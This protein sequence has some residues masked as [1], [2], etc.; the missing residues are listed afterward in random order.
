M[1]LKDEIRKTKIECFMIIEKHFPIKRQIEL[2]KAAAL[3]D[4]DEEKIKC[5]DLIEEFLP[6]D[7]QVDWFKT[8]ILEGTIN[9]VYLDKEN[10]DITPHK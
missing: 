10:N 2:L 5:V 1:E 9:V 6:I 3:K 7:E 8:L 4:S